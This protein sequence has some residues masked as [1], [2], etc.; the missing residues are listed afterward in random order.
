MSVRVGLKVGQIR[1]KMKLILIFLMINLVGVS[2]SGCLKS[3]Q[4]CRR[5]Y[6][7]RM[8]PS[9]QGEAMSNFKMLQPGGTA[10]QKPFGIN[11]FWGIA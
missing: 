11:E 4:K 10:G 2:I 1:R 8:P 9:G 7:A 5:G 6:R 3:A